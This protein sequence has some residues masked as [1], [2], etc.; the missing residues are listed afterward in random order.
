MRPYLRWR[1]WP[2][3]G[4]GRCANTGGGEIGLI[5]F[6]GSF[7]VWQGGSTWG[8]RYLVTI[9]PLLCLPLAAY[10]KRNADNIAAMV[11]LAG[12]GL[13]GFLVNGLAVLFD[14]NRGWQNLWSLGAS[15]W[16]IIWTPQFSLIGAH[17]RLLR[18]WYRHSKAALT[19]TWLPT[20]DGC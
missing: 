4:E 9:A 14:F 20:P 16:H 3:S 2:W 7:H 11:L 10:V 13:F 18:L 6:Y 1:G 19:F 5:V 12:L 8:P 17:L 15:P